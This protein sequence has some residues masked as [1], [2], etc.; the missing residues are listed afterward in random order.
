M[1]KILVIEDD[2]NIRESLAE[3]L[4]TRSYQIFSADNGAAAITLIHKHNPDLIICDVM[5]PGM[6]GYEVLEIIRKDAAT[7]TV[8][9]IF[10]SAK[11]ME[12]DREKGLSLGANSYLTKPFRST[13]LFEVVD[14]LL[15]K[16]GKGESGG[17]QILHDFISDINLIRKL[18][19]WRL[20][21][22]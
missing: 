17:A 16:S 12:A 22:S 13:E 20:S 4:E 7:A 19:G 10:L 6:S 3:L 21:L 11:V 15:G 8:P 2:M 18:F 5:M 1:K 9:F 14:K